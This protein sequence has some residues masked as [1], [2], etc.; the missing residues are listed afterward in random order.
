MM[1]QIA[2]QSI[3]LV[4]IILLFHFL[5]KQILGFNSDDGNSSHQSTVVQTLAF[6]AFVFAQIW[7]SFNSRCLD[8]TLNDFK[9][10]TKNWHFI[11][12]TTI[13]SSLLPEAALF[14]ISSYRGCCTSLDMPC[15]WSRVPSHPHERERM[16]HSPRSW[17]CRT[18]T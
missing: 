6:N 13:G 12:I 3:Y 4:F 10:V 7:N 14:L 16:G 8:R 1:K 9:G 15:W 11:A 17:F 5:G 2:G 18:P